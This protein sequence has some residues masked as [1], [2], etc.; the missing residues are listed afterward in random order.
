[1]GGEAYRSIADGGEDIE[2]S[3]SPEGV[4]G[5]QSAAKGLMEYV[6]DA[7]TP[8][9]AE[10]MGSAETPTLFLSNVNYTKSYAVNQRGSIFDS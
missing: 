8:T 2:L 4:D 7:S 10:E 5:L 6:T 9:A 1:M 3:Q